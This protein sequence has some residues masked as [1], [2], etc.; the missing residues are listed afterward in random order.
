MWPQAHHGEAKAIKGRPVVARRREQRFLPGAPLTVAHRAAL[1]AAAHLP[2]P[3]RLVLPVDGFHYVGAKDAAQLVISTQVAEVDREH[4]GQGRGRW[5]RAGGV[6]SGLAH[7]RSRAQWRCA[8]LLGR[9]WE[10]ERWWEWE[11]ACWERGRGPGGALLCRRACATTGQCSGDEEGC[12]AAG[13]A[14]WTA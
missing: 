3:L 1:A 2:P 9:G 11:T 5:R 4:R 7:L 6:G 10:G 8:G 12:R 13:V 14:P